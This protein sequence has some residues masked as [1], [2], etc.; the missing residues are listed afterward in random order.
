MRGMKNPGD[1]E[2]LEKF[3]KALSLSSL[4]GKASL[5]VTEKKSFN[6]Q[7]FSFFFF[8]FL[9]WLKDIPRRKGHPTVASVH[10]NRFGLKLRPYETVSIT[11]AQNLERSLSS[12]HNR[13]LETNLKRDE[14]VE[15]LLRLKTCILD[16]LLA[17]A[18]V[19][20]PAP[21]SLFLSFSFSRRIP[22]LSSSWKFSHIPMYPTVS[23]PRNRLKGSFVTF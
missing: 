3:L 16:H 5:G 23:E 22:S 14:A 1:F 4:S 8:F 13:A 21:L 15:I 10:W 12:E 20:I 18:I 2:G 17:F 19:K 9:R 7:T 6:E 11:L